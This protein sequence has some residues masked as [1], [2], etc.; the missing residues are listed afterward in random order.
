M[1]SST[2][3][4]PIGIT[5]FDPAGGFTLESGISWVLTGGDDPEPE[6]DRY[7]DNE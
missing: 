6:K 4:S 2:S 3:L 7:K 5:G 1:L